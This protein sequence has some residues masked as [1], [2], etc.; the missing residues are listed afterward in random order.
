VEDK[1]SYI[2]KDSGK[3]KE[4]KSG[5]KRDTDEG[6]LRYDLIPT[7]MLDR[8]AGLYTR[9]AVKYG[10]ME[11][12]EWRPVP[13]LI[14]IE[15]SSYGKIRK[16]YGFIP[17]TWFNKWGYELVSLSGQPKRHYQVH[18]LVASAFIGIS[19]L[20]VNHIDGDKTNNNIFNLEYVTAKENSQHARK[21]GLVTP[22][23]VGKITFEAAEE[24]RTLVYSGKK[25][26]QVAKIFGISPQTVC[27]IMKRRIWDKKIE[28]KIIQF[29]SN[30]KLAEDKD[31]IERFKQSAWRHFL[32]W[33]AGRNT[34]EDHA[35]AVVFN[36]FA[37]EYLTKH[38]PK[39]L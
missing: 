29:D 14:D 15:A 38:K 7:E 32:D 27:D 5:F 6:K 35:M 37:Y 12:E 20:Q 17:K 23:Q 19:N 22:P 8:I 31:A 36:I 9:G 3:R 34:E 13:N 4:W 1:M 21:M 11:V 10:K 30:W 2:T 28:K 33:Q 24:I 26:N 39:D 18:R 16:S 25:Q